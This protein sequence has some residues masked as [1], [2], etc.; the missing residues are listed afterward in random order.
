MKNKFLK[1][2]SVLTIIAASGGVSGASRLGICQTKE[3]DKL[4]E[5]KKF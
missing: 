2:L 4:R 1:I 3:T 5:L